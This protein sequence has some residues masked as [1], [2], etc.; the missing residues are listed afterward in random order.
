M[1][2]KIMAAVAALLIAVSVP[3]AAQRTQAEADEL[4]RAAALAMEIAL[5]EMTLEMDRFA[6]GDSNEMPDRQGVAA[7][8]LAACARLHILENSFDRQTGMPTVPLWTDG[9]V[10]SWDFDAAIELAISACTRDLQVLREIVRS[11]FEQAM[12]SDQAGIGIAVDA[13]T[14]GHL[15]A[16]RRAINLWLINLSVEWDFDPD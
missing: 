14:D 11:H 13:W 4:V 3:T 9:T 5:Q 6:P 8:I 2:F 1:R 16:V 7:D 12:P 10:H 15:F